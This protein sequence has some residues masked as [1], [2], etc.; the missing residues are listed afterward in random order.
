M[1]YFRVSTNQFL[2][3]TNMQRASKALLAGATILL[4]FH[5]VVFLVY[6]FNLINFPF[7]YDQ[8][9]GFEL[10]DTVLFSQ[11]EWPY[12][13]TEQFPFYSS[14]YPPLFHVIAAP[15]VWAFGPA[16]WYGRLLGTVGTLAAGAMIGYAVYRETQH[17][18]IAAL[19]G[20][21]FVGSNTV[22]HIGP[23]FRQHMAMVALETAAVVILAQVNEIEA[24]Q[25]RRWQL[26][27]GLGLI[28]A[29]GYTKQLAAVTALAAGLFLFLRQPRRAIVWGM[30]AAVV[31]AGVFVWMNTATGGEWWRQAILANVNEIKIL[32]TVALFRQWI[33]LHGFLIVPAVIVVVHD[34]YFNRLSI[35]TVWFVAATAVN[36]TFS[37]TWGGGDSYFTT[38]IAGVCILSGIFAGRT[39]KGS[40]R[41]PQNYLTRWLVDPMRPAAHALMRAGLVIVPLLYLGYGRA[42]LHMPT[43]GPV[44]S[45]VASVFNI[46]PNALNGFYDSARTADG[47]Y[48]TGYANIGHLVTQADIEAGWRIVEMIRAEPKLVLSEE[49]GFSLMAGREVITNPT[50]LLNLEKKGLYNGSEL[51]G[52]IEDQAFGMVI[53]RAQFYPAAVLVAISAAYEQVETVAMNGFQYLILRPR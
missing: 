17:R 30:L 34:L 15:F 25:R 11:G 9:E 18:W 20:L 27:A 49:A 44:F 47:Q 37:G 52:M 19:S 40:W 33:G 36:G 1:T 32:Q 39:L 2:S 6:A 14:N 13:D 7:D 50:Q 41:F 48:A 29:A 28:L 53:L 35:Y 23:L 10:V 12:R 16:Y 43:E 46:Q 22:Y 24:A 26:A 21:A 38:S 42:V 5:V 3:M 31:G 8:G 51:I 4:A 45:T